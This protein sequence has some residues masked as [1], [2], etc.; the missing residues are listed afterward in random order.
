M[1]KVVLSVAGKGRGEVADEAGTGIIRTVV[2]AVAITVVE[3]VVSPTMTMEGRGVV[4]VSVKV[5]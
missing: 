2:G 5:R 3:A 4:E 1:V